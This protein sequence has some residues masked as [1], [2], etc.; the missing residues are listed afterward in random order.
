MGTGLD[1]GDG[2][3]SVSVSNVGVVVY[4]GRIKSYIRM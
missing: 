1:R 3:V 4:R 2:A